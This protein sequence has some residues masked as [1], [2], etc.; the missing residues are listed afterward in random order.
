MSVKS[1]RFTADEVRA[2]L[3]GRK[4]TKRLVVKPANVKKAAGEGYRQGHGLWIDLSA[5]NGDREGHIKDYSVSPL[6]VTLGWYVNRYSPYRPGDILWVRE[7]F[8]CDGYDENGERYVYGTDVDECGRVVWGDINKG[9]W[10]PASD[11]H[12]RPSIH[13]PREAARIWLR[14]TDVRVERLWEIDVDGIRAEGL[15]SACVH[16]GDMEIA[17][18]EFALLWDS[19][20]KHADLDRYGWAASPWVW[21]IA[22]E[23]CEKPEEV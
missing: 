7:K 13:M 17:M 20:I 18:Q 23:R 5:D 1:I 2:T 8:A 15:T 22:F 14:V 9:E 16:V 12:W 6:W 4:T 21:V 11:Y 3:D 19:T 10:T